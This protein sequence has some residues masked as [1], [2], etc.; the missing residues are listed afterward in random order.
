MEKK[1]KRPNWLG[2]MSDDD[3]AIFTAE[4]LEDCDGDRLPS[5]SL[6]L[7]V[8][9][10]GGLPRA[11]IIEYW[12]AD[13]AG[14]TSMA[15]KAAAAIL[16]SDEKAKVGYVGLEDML[17]PKRVRA[18]GI[19]EDDRFQVVYVRLAEKALSLIYNM[20]K[21]KEFSLIIL[22]SIPA[23]LARSDD[24][25]EVGAGAICAYHRL[26]NHFLRKASSILGI[27]SK[28]TNL[29][30]LLTINQVRER[31]VET[32]G[33]FGDDREIAPGG[34]GLRH[35]KSLSIKFTKIGRLTADVG[36]EKETV[37]IRIQFTITKSKIRGCMEGNQ[38]IIDLYNKN[39]PPFKAGD[40]DYIKD[41]RIEA[42]KLGIIS[43]AGAYYSYEGR[44]FHGQ[45][46]L[47]K[48]LLEQ[49]EIRAKLRGE[50]LNAWRQKF[51]EGF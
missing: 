13:S 48:Y 11:R 37:G 45:E 3:L 38:G 12:G 2:R 27:K 30:S 14:K 32:W 5:G 1:K 47:D 28:D 36:G 23:L 8:A 40:I 16:K 6:S 39:Y 20:I 44:K 51:E 31:F 24:K 29:T 49:S 50:V 19:P 25:G 46:E 34:R 41:V 15:L 17:D 7:D 35:W 10:G 18:L 43:R 4:D 9:L 21:S 33:S 22:D 42:C 26:L